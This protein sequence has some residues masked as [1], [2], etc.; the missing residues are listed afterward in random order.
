MSGTYVLPHDQLFVLDSE[1]ATDGNS[2]QCNC[3]IRH[4]LLSNFDSHSTTN[5]ES[6]SSIDICACMNVHNTSV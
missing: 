4:K 5:V 1:A 6:L 2:Y 3:V